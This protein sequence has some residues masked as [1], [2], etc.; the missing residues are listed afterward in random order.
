MGPEHQPDVLGQELERVQHP[1]IGVQID[2]GVVE[3]ADGVGIGLEL[4]AENHVAHAH[5][6]GQHHQGAH[7]D[8][9]PL[10]HGQAAAAK[11]PHDV[12]EGDGGDDQDR[13][14]LGQQAHEEGQQQGEA[15]TQAH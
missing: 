4:P 12:G 8:E 2:E 3:L 5:M 7:V 9:D 15:R 13:A 6:S 14:L 11:G 1:Q 10:T